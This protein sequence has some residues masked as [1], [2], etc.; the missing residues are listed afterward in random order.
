MNARQY[1]AYTA[2]VASFLERNNVR[3]GCLGPVNAENSE[4]FFSWQPCEC[5][6]SHLGGNREEYEF[7]T[8]DGNTFK[9]NI[10]TDCI[11]FLA[12]GVLDDMTML[13]IEASKK[14]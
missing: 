2:S 8:Q 10:C 1:E 7:V 4:P 13:E 12:Y 5:C 3:E 9:A 6:G 11:Y 14:A